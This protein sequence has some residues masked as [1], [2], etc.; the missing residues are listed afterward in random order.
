MTM[1]QS[2]VVGKQYKICANQTGH[3]FSI[4]EVVVATTGAA[5]TAAGRVGSV[6]MR[7]VTTGRVYGVYFDDIAE[8]WNTRKEQA[9]FLAEE[10]KDLEKKIVELKRSQK[11]LS[12]FDS[13]EEEIASVLIKATD[14]SELPQ[15]ERIANLAKLLKGRLKTDLI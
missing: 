4:G 10:I 2:I 5:Q 3:G 7:G 6:S 8:A 9:A 14:N 1:P 13:D 11:R 12:E 15:G